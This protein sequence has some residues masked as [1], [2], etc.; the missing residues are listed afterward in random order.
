MSE[1]QQWSD[2]VTSVPRFCSADRQ[3]QTTPPEHMFLLKDQSV[4]MVWYLLTD[5][6][7]IAI[8]IPL[9]AKIHAC[10]NTSDA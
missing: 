1:T 9:E 4:T 5:T 6:P 8:Q 2:K 10:K 7:K 3:T